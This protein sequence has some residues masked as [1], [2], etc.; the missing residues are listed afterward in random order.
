MGK[1]GNAERG[2]ANLSSHVVTDPS[3]S[4]LNASV[5]R[6]KSGSAARPLPMGNREH[7][8]DTNAR[9]NAM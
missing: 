9:T 4:A 3:R 1:S 2:S 7:L 8:S 6:P 5:A